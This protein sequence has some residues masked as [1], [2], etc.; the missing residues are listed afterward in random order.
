MIRRTKFSEQAQK[1]LL[2]LALLTYFVLVVYP[3]LWVLLSSFKVSSQVLNSRNPLFE[4]P[5]PRFV[6]NYVK[7]W[8]EVHF[9]RYFFNSVFITAVSVLATLTIGSMAAYVLG[10]F[11]YRI[12]PALTLYFLGGLMVPFQMGLIPLFFLVLKLGLFNTYTGLILLYTAGSLPFTIWVLTG[13][14]ASLPGSLAEA[15]EI[16]GASPFQVFWKVMLPLARP[17]LLTVAIF[18]FLGTWNEYFMALVFI[19]EER[20][21]TL[22]LGLASL[23]IQKQYDTD[24]GALFA[25]VVIVML[26]TL[27]VY[28]LLQ[29]YITKGITA[30]AVKA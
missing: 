25:G 19:T 6:G 21:K 22:P 5:Q 17:G 20:L 10:T 18:N 13:F 16:D 4:L 27:L 29:N 3:M 15:A 28:G 7:A 24:Y 8:V 14:F 11:P 9:S 12:N 23:S 30:G 26:P 1:A 2:Y